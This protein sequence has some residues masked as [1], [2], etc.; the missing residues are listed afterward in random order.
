MGFIKVCHTRMGI[1]LGFVTA[2]L[3]AVAPIVVE[4]LAPGLLPEHQCSAATMLRI[5]APAI[6]FSGADLW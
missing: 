1:L 6:L 5:M 3:V 2:S 4:V